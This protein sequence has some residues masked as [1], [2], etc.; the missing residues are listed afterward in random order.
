M[1]WILVAAPFARGRDAAR[2][3]G[4]RRGA[5]QRLRAHR[6]RQG[7]VAANGAAGTAVRPS[8][9]PVASLIGAWV[10][11]FVTNMVLVEFVFF[12][13]GFLG[14]SRRAFGQAPSRW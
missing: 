9:A 2:A 3:G 4:D 10:P 6:R 14:L 13:P 11:T 5:R 12:I 7:A 1:P 8:Y